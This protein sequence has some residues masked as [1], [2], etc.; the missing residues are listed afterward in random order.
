VKVQTV[1]MIPLAFRADFSSIDEEKRTVSLIFSTGAPV[2]RFD[3]VTGKRYREVLSMDPA[4][5]RTERL[6]TVGNLLDA[7]SAWSVGDVLG[8][9]EPGSVRIEGGRGLADVR[10]SRRADVEPVW[11]DVRDKIVRSVSVGY[12]VYR[13]VEDTG[14]DNQIATRTAVDWEPY[15]VS[16]VPMPAD[17]G[18]R[19]R[20]G[21]KS[22]THPCVIELRTSDADRMRRLRLAMAAR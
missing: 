16:L 5:I 11:Q 7:H 9:V 22:C 6:N 4:H 3:W 21:D 13:Y 18:A 8:A 19:V 2:T 20:S 1:D 17:M 14:K 15:E 12:N 10:F